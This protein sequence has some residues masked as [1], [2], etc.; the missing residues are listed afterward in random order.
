MMGCKPEH[1]LKLTREGQI[2]LDTKEAFLSRIAIKTF[3]GYA[4]DQFDR[5]EHGLLGNGKNDSKYM[6]MLK[7]SLERSIES[8]YL[9]YGN[10]ELNLNVDI[11]AKEDDIDLWNKYNHSEKMIQLE[12][13]I[14]ITGDINRCPIT[15]LKSAMNG[16]IGVYN[17][18]GRL[19][20]RNTKKDGVH[21][22]KHMMHLLRLYFMAIDLNMGKGIV[23]YRE[24]EHDL[25]M[26]IRNGKY[27]YEDGER[28][29]P[30]F[31]ELLHDVQNQYDEVIKNT[32]LPEKPDLDKITEAVGKSTNP[33]NYLLAQKYIQALQDIATGNDTKTVYLPYEASNMMGA[34][35][36]IKDLFKAE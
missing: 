34:I 25:L 11:I 4:R 15:R 30:E 24:K 29:R 23:T 18:F 6:D 32:V 1:Y 27:M 20:K 7:H 14:Y 3:G 22:A 17:D 8:F 35:G 28:V 9:I 10:S 12:K 31:Y 36:G 16:L 2:L 26:D 5:L 13:D 21:L 19:N 33:A